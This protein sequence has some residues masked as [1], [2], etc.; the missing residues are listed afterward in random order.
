MK[1]VAI[2]IL[3]IV[4]NVGLICSGVYCGISWF[5]KAHSE[6]HI[7]GQLNIDNSYTTESFTYSA[8]KHPIVFYHD[9]Y[10]DTDLYYFSEELEKVPSFDGSKK[11]YEITLN[12]YLILEPTILFRAISFRVP[13]VFNDLDGSLLCDTYF[14]VVIKFY[15]DKTKFEINVIGNENSQ[16]VDHYIQANGFELFVMEVTR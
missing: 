2:Y 7:I 9:D 6:S 10:D 8:A 12:D 11:Q 5:Q 1:R 14:D 15:T 16:F 4:L 3:V 13:I